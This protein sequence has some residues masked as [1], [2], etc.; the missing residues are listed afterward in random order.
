MSFA[1]QLQRY[2]A[3][4]L[5][6]CFNC[7]NCT[8]ICPLSS[9]STSF[10]RKQIRYVQLGLE[11]K[12]LEVPDAWLCYYCAD[13]SDTCPRKAE[14]G[15]IMMA[16]R[17]YMIAKYGGVIAKWLYTSRL[18]TTLFIGLTSLFALFLITFFHGSIDMTSVRLFDFLPISSIELVGIALGII[19][20]VTAL[21][22]FVK[23]GINLHRGI[24]KSPTS[25]KPSVWKWVKGFFLTLVLEAFAQIRY[26]K[27]KEEGKRLRHVAIHVAPH[28]AMLWGFL[29]LLLTTALR[30]TIV[31]T[32]GE[33]VPLTEP[34]RLLGIVCGILLLYGSGMVIINRLLKIDKSDTYSTYTDWIF[35]ILLFLS[36]VTGILLTVFHYASSPLWSYVTLSLHLIVVFELILLAPFTK[37]IHSLYRAMAIWISRVHGYV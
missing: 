4:N 9:E 37:F 16:I 12:L 23:L 2:G 10:P 35:V 22:G 18:F 7:G 31:P 34:T 5:A 21:Y 3:P 13:C 33:V 29:G 11:R 36:G 28:L 26:F 17:R 19:I 24:P 20:G 6:I 14:P 27:C 1:K 15:E 25:T 8:A 30:F 32:H